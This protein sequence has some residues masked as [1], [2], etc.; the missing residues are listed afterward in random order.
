M[1]LEFHLMD[2]RPGVEPDTFVTELVQH[3]LT[4]DMERVALRRN[5]RAM[6]GFQWKNVFLPEGTSLR[7]S[8]HEVIEFAKVVGDRILS[9]DGRSLTPSLFANRH[10][11]GRNAWRLIW[12]RFPGNDYWIRATDYR[13][14]ADEQLRNTSKDWNAERNYGSL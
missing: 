1:K 12:L 4:I 6:R 10:A 7:T 9:D 3:W 11:K 2:T 14:R 8:Y 13:A 5:G